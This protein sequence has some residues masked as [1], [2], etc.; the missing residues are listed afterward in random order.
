[1][2]LLFCESIYLSDKNAENL[3]D[4]KP[5]LYTEIHLIETG[6]PVLFLSFYYSAVFYRSG[7]I[8]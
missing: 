1:M 5:I 7:L 4:S 8:L 3:D 6:N 2:N